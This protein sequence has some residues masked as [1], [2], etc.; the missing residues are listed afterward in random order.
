MIAAREK[1]LNVHILAL[2][3]HGE[4]M[5]S[6]KSITT[7]GKDGQ[8]GPGSMTP[9][10][11]IEIPEGLDVVSPSAFGFGVAEV[12]KLLDELHPQQISTAVR[13]TRMKVNDTCFR[14]GMGLACMFIAA[15]V[16]SRY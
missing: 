10:L 1:Q 14:W 5:L 9:H 16:M 7:T 13:R 3:E 8:I 4:D 6:M 12:D 11:D 15:F 2:F